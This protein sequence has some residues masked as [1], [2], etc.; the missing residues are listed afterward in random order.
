MASELIIDVLSNLSFI[1]Y[2]ISAFFMTKVTDYPFRLLEYYN[3]YWLTLCLA[4][5][6]YMKIP[7]EEP[8]STIIISK[9]GFFLALCYADILYHYFA[10][11]T[12][13]SFPVILLGLY[14]INMGINAH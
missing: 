6:M 12:L 1:S 14:L 7:I 4:V 13:I 10:G 3:M 5:V 2:A 8:I 9:N 11:S